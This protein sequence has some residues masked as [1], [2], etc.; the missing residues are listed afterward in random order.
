MGLWCPP[1]IH[2]TK[3][4]VFAFFISATSMKTNLETVRFMLALEKILSIHR[5]YIYLSKRKRVLLGILVML[6]FLLT[7]PIYLVSMFYIM[8]ERYHKLLWFHYV[9]SAFLLAIMLN[10]WSVALFYG[11][12][13]GK[14]WKQMLIYLQRNDRFARYSHVYEKS[15]KRLKLKCYLI[16][17]IFTVLRTVFVIPVGIKENLD[18][19]VAYDWYNLSV[20]YLVRHWSEYL[21]LLE[22]MFCYYLL[23]ILLNLLKHLGT[24]IKDYDSRGD[25]SKKQ[26]QNYIKMYND[27]SECTKLLTLCFGQQ[28]STN[29]NTG[30]VGSL[31]SIFLLGLS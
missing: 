26:L 6:E 1:L 31:C 29:K 8:G 25:A 24:L 28:V 5:D 20:Y 7:T 19:H 2:S 14:E 16:L 17:V 3:Y 13:N 21:Y 22:V 18:K 15:M 27:V 23:S 12:R 10:G 30:P 4:S 9:T 11:P